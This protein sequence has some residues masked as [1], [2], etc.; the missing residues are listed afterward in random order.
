MDLGGDDEG[1]IDRTM[2]EIEIGMQRLS[3]FQVFNNLVACLVPQ[4]NQTLRTP[5]QLIRVLRSGTEVNPLF[6][7][8]VIG[9]RTIQT[10][11]RSIS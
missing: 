3:P 10:T 2:S 9:A 6:L 8:Y 5:E 11:S 1:Q 7:G 4:W